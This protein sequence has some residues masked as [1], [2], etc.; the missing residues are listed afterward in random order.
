VYLRAYLRVRALNLVQV[1]ASAV[2]EE[3]SEAGALAIEDE[4]AYS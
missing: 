3:V 1:A 4:V 2:L